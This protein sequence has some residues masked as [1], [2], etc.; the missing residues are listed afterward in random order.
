MSLVVPISLIGRTGIIFASDWLVNPP[1]FLPRIPEPGTS[2]FSARMGFD[3]HM[4]SSTLSWL[5]SNSQKLLFLPFFSPIE[6]VKLFK[7]CVVPASR[8][9][10]ALILD[11][12][13]LDSPRLVIDFAC[14]CLTRQRKFHDFFV[15]RYR[16][17]RTSKQI[18]HAEA[19]PQPCLPYTASTFTAWI[20]YA[21]R[22]A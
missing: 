12:L 6:R 4:A 1:F 18:F 13:F 8:S 16:T 19:F 9:C 20:S 3:H 22:T 11:A 17:S 7:S 21:L 14:F 5:Y 15:M 2:T 10:T